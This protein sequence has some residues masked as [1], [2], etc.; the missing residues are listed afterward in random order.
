MAAT[1]GTETTL[2]ARFQM[3]KA[4]ALQPPKS[5]WGQLACP[6]GDSS[7]RPCFSFPRARGLSGARSGEAQR[8][9]GMQACILVPT[10]G[11]CQDQRA[12]LSWRGLAL[13]YVS[14]WF[15]FQECCKPR[16]IKWQSWLWWEYLYHGN[17]Q[18][19]PTGHLFFLESW[20]LNIYLHTLHYRASPNRQGSLAISVGRWRR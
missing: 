15:S 19:L 16:D 7:G 11:L 1:K 9:P 20:M 2:E 10:S 3:P 12:V 18:V 13:V 8:G 4:G 6:R 5:P 17:W 14:C